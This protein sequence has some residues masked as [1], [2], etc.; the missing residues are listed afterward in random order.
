MENRTDRL[1]QYWEQLE[2]FGL[3]RRDYPDARRY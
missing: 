1:E 2:Q 3:E